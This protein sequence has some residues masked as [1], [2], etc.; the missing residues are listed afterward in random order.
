MGSADLGLVIAHT[1]KVELRA[2]VEYRVSPLGESAQSSLP[3]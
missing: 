2:L 1:K 3:R